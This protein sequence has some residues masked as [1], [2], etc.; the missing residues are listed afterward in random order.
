MAYFFGSRVGYRQ[1]ERVR[2]QNFRD[3]IMA[4]EKGITIQNEPGMSARTSESVGTFASLGISNFRLLVTGT[5]LSNA[6]QWV[7]LVT[8]NWLVYDLT[9][10][11]TMLGTVNLVR[12]FASLGMIPIAGILIDRLKRRQVMVATNCWLFLITLVM[13]LLLLFGHQ[14]LWF[15]FVF[16]FLAGLAQAVDM[17]LRQ[18]VVFDLVPRLLTPNGLAMVQTGWSLMRSFGPGIGGFLILWFGPGGNFLFQAAAYILIAITIMRIQFPERKWETRHSSVEKILEGIRY[19]VRERSTRTFMIVGLV[20]PLFIIPIY[21]VLPPV[22]AVQVFG[23]KS[24]EI[25]GILMACVGV[26]GIFGGIVTASLGGVDRRG[27]VQLSSLLLLGLTLIGFA[28]SQQLWVALLLLMLSGFFEMIYLTN[29]QT[30]LQLSI[31]DKLRGRVTSVVNLNSALFPL[32]GLLAGVGS[33]LLGGPK[34]ITML[35][36]GTSAGIAICF[37]LA[38]KTVRN[39]RLSEAIAQE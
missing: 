17:N 20:L 39:Y 24:G 8:L 13:G 29:N 1:L 28:M 38:S 36:A 3:I 27:L 6:A 35:L 23:D 33:D 19:V 18:V 25:L 5:T 22:Y 32:G 34:T 12:A 7:Q 21:I 30:L 31:P 9:G 37:F 11:G 16:S 14:Q 2:S 10:S 4:L 26:G 15:L